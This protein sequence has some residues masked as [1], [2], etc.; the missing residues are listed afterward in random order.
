MKRDMDLARKIMLAVEAEP[1]GNPAPVVFQIDGYDEETVGYHIYLLGQG[2]FMD[3]V[4]MGCFQDSSP[5]ALPGPLTW[6]GHDWLDATRN[7]TIWNKVKSKLS[8]EGVTV[9]F[10]VA[11]ALATSLVMAR[12]GLGS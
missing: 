1:H 11:K 5:S 10:D 12:L 6:A 3:V 9:S 7:D 4:D 2:G 8:T